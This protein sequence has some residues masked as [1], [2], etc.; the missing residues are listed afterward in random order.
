MDRSEGIDKKD[1][2]INMHYAKLFKE[3]NNFD[4]SNLEQ[5]IDLYKTSREDLAAQIYAK[6]KEKETLLESIKAKQFYREL[7][8]MRMEYNG[9]VKQRQ[10]LKSK[11]TLLAS[12][13]H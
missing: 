5:K 13:G 11:K 8:L 2:D 1:K 6:E 10:A 3:F 4:R 9:L 7:M 12:M